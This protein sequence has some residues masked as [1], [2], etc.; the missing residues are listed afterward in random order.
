MKVINPFSINAAQYVYGIFYGRKLVYIGTTCD[1]VRRAK[2]HNS[3]F[4]FHNLVILSEGGQREESE[5]KHVAIKY[6]MCSHKP[7]FKQKYNNEQIRI[8]KKTLKNTIK[9]L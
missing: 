7:D 1:P 8:I 5:F 9:S 2:E 6:K 3:R 4:K